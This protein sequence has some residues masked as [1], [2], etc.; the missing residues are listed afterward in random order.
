MNNVFVMSHASDIDGVGAAALIRMKYNV[1]LSHIFFSEYSEEAVYYV[2]EGLLHVYGKGITLFITDLGVDDRLIKGYLRII[3]GVR[4]GGGRVFWFDHHPWSDNAIMQ[5][6]KRCYAAI[7][8]ENPRYCGTEITFRELGIGG[9]FAKEFVKIVHYSDF[10]IKPRTRREYDLVGLYTLS[11]TS[12]A[13]LKSRNARTSKLRH[14]ANVISSGRLYDKSMESDARRFDIINRKRIRQMLSGMIVRK[15]FAVGFSKGIQSTA[16][17]IAVREAAKRPIG[18]YVN[19]KDW[20]GHIRCENR[21]ISAFAMNLG[22]GGHPHASGFFIDPR[23]FGY[24]ISKRQKERFADF[25]EKK[26][27]LL[28]QWHSGSES[29]AS[30]STYR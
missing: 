7:V 10:N 13:E 25:L 14:M 30:G 20:K 26:I 22:G 3:N 2:H 27:D 6:A 4:S 9:R 29:E 23:R 17:C 12:Y 24:L 18:I 15:R 19:T 5:I 28:V 11:I 8:G 21:D 16:G 1:P